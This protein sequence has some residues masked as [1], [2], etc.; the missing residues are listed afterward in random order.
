MKK[1][2]ITLIKKIDHGDVISSRNFNNIDL[3]EALDKRDD[4]PFDSDWVLANSQMESKFQLQKFDQDVLDLIDVIREKTF[5]TTSQSI[6]GGEVSEYVCD[7]FELISK[8]I[9]ISSSDPWVASLLK[10]YLDGEF[11]VGSL[12]L[13]KIP[14][15]DLI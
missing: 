3:D 4:D 2:L 10:A 14:V 5:K 13:Q 1:K 11:P 15:F 7:D 6:G 8:S 12:R 9:L